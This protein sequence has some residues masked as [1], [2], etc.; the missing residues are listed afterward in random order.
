M[1]LG[2]SGLSKGTGNLFLGSSARS[3]LPCRTCEVLRHPHLGRSA[4]QAGK[5]ELV[6][7]KRLFALEM[8]S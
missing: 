6:E 3:G 8:L 4:E 5:K 7:V 2:R 1:R